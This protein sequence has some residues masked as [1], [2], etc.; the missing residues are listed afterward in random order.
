MTVEPPAD[1]AYSVTQTDVT[2]RKDSNLRQALSFVLGVDPKTADEW[3][4]QNGRVNAEAKIR[5][6]W[7]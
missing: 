3:I 4:E 5:S 6:Y 2:P 7:L 1:E